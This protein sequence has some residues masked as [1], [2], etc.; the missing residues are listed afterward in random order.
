MRMETGS[1]QENSRVAARIAWDIARNLVALV[2]ATLLGAVVVSQ[3][4]YVHLIPTGAIPIAPLVTGFLA[5]VIVAVIAPRT[6]FWPRFLVF[7]AIYLIDL[8]LS[9]ALSAFAGWQ[10]KTFFGGDSE[11]AGLWTKTRPLILI[12]TIAFGYLTL[13]HYREPLPRR[14]EG[15]I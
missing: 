9:V 5:C 13:R 8:G 10:V 15:G 3:V 12:T 11:A 6:K 7:F 1:A 4:I 14:E 2:I